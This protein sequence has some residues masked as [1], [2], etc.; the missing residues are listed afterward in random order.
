M[1]IEQSYVR[2]LKLTDVPSL[3]PIDVML[4][5]FEPGKGRITIRCYTESW[6]AYWGA[7][8]GR[9]VSDFFCSCDNGYIAS[10]L[11]GGLNQLITDCEAIE[12]HIRRR[13]I[14]LRRAGDLEKADAR[15]LYDEAGSG[16]FVSIDSLWHWRRAGEILG[17]EWWHAMPQRQNP[18]YLYLCRVIDAVREG[19]KLT[20]A[21]ETPANVVKEA[22][23]GRGRE[24]QVEASGDR[25][26]LGLEGDVCAVIKANEPNR[27]QVLDE[28]FAPF[29]YLPAYADAPTVL[30]AVRMF[31]RGYEQ[32]T[33]R[34]RMVLQHEL[35]TLLGAAGEVS[36][37]GR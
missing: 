13:V 32:G 16:K 23:T 21:E 10:Y 20:A 36:D 30:A 18:K 17:E 24:Y 34:G 1:K 2:Q 29:G 12:E 26:L 27:L 8:S 15:D 22:P 28:E 14:E 33:T 25:W 19:L 31:N 6:T 7:M 35:R 37:D 3:D 5:D 4:E 11:A 9:T